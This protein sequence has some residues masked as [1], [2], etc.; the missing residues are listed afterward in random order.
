M[1][2]KLVKNYDWCIKLNPLQK[3]FQGNILKSFQ[4]GGEEIY[5][6]NPAKEELY[7]DA[8]EL[9]DRIPTSG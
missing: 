1:N 6:T 8:K 3:V 7:N 5:S 4:G 9:L 2:L